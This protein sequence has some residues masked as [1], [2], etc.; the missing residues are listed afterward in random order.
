MVLPPLAR[1][2]SEEFFSLLLSLAMEP[3]SG[4][5]ARSG[6]K[7][8]QVSGTADGR[9]HRLSTA[10]TLPSRAEASSDSMTSRT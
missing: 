7:L 2:L 9:S 6:T 4:G 1:L 5:E 8:G 10:T 3:R